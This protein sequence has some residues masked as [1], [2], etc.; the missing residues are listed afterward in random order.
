MAAVL[1]LWHVCLATPLQPLPGFSWDTVPVFIETSN[2]TGAFDAAALSA[3]A[4]ANLFV[5]EKGYD[6][7]NKSFTEDKALALV[8]QL[9]ALRTQS[10][11]APQT[12]IFYYNSNLDLPDARLH[13]VMT[14]IDGLLRNDDG[15]IATTHID[16]GHPAFPYNFTYVYDHTQPMARQQWVE[17]CLNMTEAGF[18]GCMV[19]RWTRTPKVQDVSKARMSAWAQ[20]RDNAT[21]A[22]IARMKGLGA[23]KNAFLVSGGAGDLRTDLISFPGFGYKL[24]A[25][26]SP[27]LQALNASS[28]A[29]RGFLASTRPGTVDNPQAK[30]DQLAAFLIGASVNSFFGAGSWACDHTHREGVAWW[31][32][33]DYP[34]GAPHGN[35]SYDPHSKVWRRSFGNGTIVSFGSERT[36]QGNIEWSSAPPPPPAPPTPTPG[37]CPA[38]N[39]NCMWHY[40]DLKSSGRARDWRTCCGM[41][42]ST[43]GCNK[44][45]WRT[46]GTCHL[47]NA[48]A[49]PAVSASCF[50]GEMRALHAR[51]GDRA[52]A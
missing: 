49:T 21:T 15:S 47:H 40:G 46:G 23:R 11:K 1:L 29:G 22:L 28:V 48:T 18:D 9:R 26:D 34:L 39:P 41:C 6:P 12:I 14:G 25:P 51:V 33:Y 7:A 24:G 43:A 32:E 4:K 3:I 10:A 35:A 2:V 19:D 42:G 36:P 52:P 8:G 44:W 50:C 20:G 5:I 38:V 37:S 45:V 31:P 17:E 30:V 13:A 27:G 16:A